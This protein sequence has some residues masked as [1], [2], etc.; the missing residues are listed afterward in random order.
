[1]SAWIRDM[2]VHKFNSAHFWSTNSFKYPSRVSA[3]DKIRTHNFSLKFR[4]VIRADLHYRKKIA[5][6]FGRR[7]ITMIFKW[8]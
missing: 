1:M 8:V 3:K 7:D 5:Q 6:G 4:M 2:S